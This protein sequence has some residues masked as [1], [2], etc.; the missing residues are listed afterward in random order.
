MTMAEISGKRPRMSRP[1]RF[2]QQMPARFVEGTFERMDRVLGEGEDRA[3]LVRMAVEAEL[4][5][6]EACT[7]RQRRYRIRRPK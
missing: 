3:T 1:P 7:R 5:R 2:V 6:R 4:L